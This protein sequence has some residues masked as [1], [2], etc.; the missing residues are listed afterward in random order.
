[1]GVSVKW[2][3][4]KAE[5]DP[6]FPKPVQI[7]GDRVFFVRD[8]VISYLKQ[9]PGSRHRRRVQADGDGPW[10]TFAAAAE[11]LGVGYDRVHELC[12]EDPNFPPRRYLENKPVFSGQ[13]FDSWLSRRAEYR[14]A[15]MAEKKA[16][17]AAR[18][19]A[20][21]KQTAERKRVW[22]AEQ[23]AAKKSGIPLQRPERDDLSTAAAAKYLGVSEQT[24]QRWRWSGRHPIPHTRHGNHVRYRRADLDEFLEKQ[25]AP[26]SA[27]RAVADRSNS[28]TSRHTERGWGPGR[29]DLPRV[30]SAKASTDSPRDS[31]P[32]PVQA[33]RWP[34][35]GPG[36]LS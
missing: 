28:G 6:A 30:Q 32:H 9:W 27:R 16:A 21:A 23:R 19:Q 13:L 35:G 7:Q 24:L 31:R 17:T 33:R 18:R 25:K 22:A 15:R 14:A 34:R 36:V 26:A 10:I 8:D 4:I 11:R 20:N 12:V 1:M 5:Q 2:V 3:R 29:G